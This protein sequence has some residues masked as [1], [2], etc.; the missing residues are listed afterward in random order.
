MEIT[1]FVVFIS[2]DILGKNTNNTFS[3]MYWMHPEVLNLK[4]PKLIQKEYEDHESDMYYLRRH[5]KGF[6]S[7]GEIIC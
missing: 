7:V 3:D 2:K 1:E 4:Y 6:F 5:V